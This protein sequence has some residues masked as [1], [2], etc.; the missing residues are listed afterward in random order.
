MQSKRILLVV[1]F[2]LLVGTDGLRANYAFKKKVISVCNSYRIT[3]ESSQFSLGENDFSI[4]LESG[5]NNF[6]MVMLVGFAAVG[7]AIEHQ[8]QMGK[9]NAYTPESITM[10]I[11]VPI[12]RG[13]TNMFVATCSKQM[14]IELA[15]GT[16][17]SSDFMQ[18]I[19]M[20]IQ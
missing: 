17:E 18:E 6:E 19:N 1:L 11:V 5:R 8:I 9:A 20:E 7:H 4:D 14:A 12:S 13:E 16:M 10:N 15:N 2:A 3:V